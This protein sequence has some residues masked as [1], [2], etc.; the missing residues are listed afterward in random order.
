MTG[1]DLLKRAG[2]LLQD[3]TFTRWRLPELVRW[4][5]DGQRAVVTAKPS[6]NS[7]SVALSLAEGTL[8]TLANPSHLLLLRIPRNLTQ[9]S[10]RLGGRVI[11]PVSRE[12]LDASAPGWHNR[13]E[14]PF[15]KEVRQYVFDEANPREFYVYPGND[16]TGLVEAVVSILPTFLAATGDPDAIASYNAPLGLPEPYGVVVL[17]YVLFRAFAKDD[18]A[19]EPARAQMHLTAFMQALGVKAEVQ[20]GHSPNSRARIAST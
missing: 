2:T 10:P 16:G 6:A 12:V 3:E 8:Q 7:T 19:G 18:I 4:I 9:A 13:A 15:R 14:T 5:N 11:R 20:A 1:A 17:D